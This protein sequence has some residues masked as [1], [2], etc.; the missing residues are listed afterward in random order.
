MTPTESRPHARRWTVT[1]IAVAA[2]SISAVSAVSAA[3]ADPP[4]G[5]ESASVAATQLSC[6]LTSFQAAARSDTTIVAVSAA[7]TPVSNCQ[8]SGYVTTYE[9]GVNKVNFQLNLPDTFNGR[10]LL[11]A[12]GGSAGFIPAP[13]PTLLSAGYALAGTDEGNQSLGLN[14][15]FAIDRAA[16]LGWDHLGVHVTAVTTQA[17][18]KRYYATRD[19][20]RYITGCSGGGRSTVQEAALYPNDFDGMATGAPGI[21]PDN[22]L[23]FMQLTQQLKRHPESWVSPAQLGQLESMILAKYDSS[24]GAVD[25]L[26]A[27]PSKV[28]LT[29]PMLAIFSAAQR[30]TLRL[31]L[32]GLHRFGQDY[33]GLS[34]SNP[35]G[36]SSFVT[37]STSPDTWTA[38]TAPPSFLVADSW[39]RGLYGLDY[40]FV[41][42]FDF[43]RRADVQ[44][45]ESTV[46]YV[47]PASRAYAADLKKF[48][49]GGGKMV[50][51]HG[52]ADNAISTY[53]TLRFYGDF[54]QQSGGY[55]K[56]QQSIRLFLAPGVFHCG[57]GPGPQDVPT[58][59]LNAVTRW[60]EGGAAPRTLIAHSAAA[61]DPRRTYLL[62]PYPQAA[63]FAGGVGNPRGLDVN[64]AENW[65]CRL[66]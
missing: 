31:V 29:E 41:V 49:R 8:V 37:G 18:T 38:T 15:R 9:R 39:M 47:Y 7:P 1:A 23:W 34:A 36:W 30:T 19:L 28:R 48:V 27:D 21:N 66:R 25:G 54:A 50:M 33:P 45:Y 17:L 64:N 46:S 62:C 35:S 59:A 56:A 51:W 65:N 20:Y 61:V 60:V 26:I 57:G 10:Y 16:A 14:Y 53:D 6:S 40:D 3:S 5:P 63:V 43:A 32:D 24:D 22:I 2:L 4:R 58:Q 13:S 44:R 52:T 12:Q 42:S 55:T 11:A